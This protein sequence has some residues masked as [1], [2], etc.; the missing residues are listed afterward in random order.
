MSSEA[1]P[2]APA[3][4]AAPA[5]AVEPAAEPAPAAAPAPPQDNSA[6][7]EARA[8][9]IAERDAA[10]MRE[11]ESQFAD[12]EKRLQQDLDA[13]TAAEN[14]A[15]EKA[16]AATS[17]ATARD[18]LEAQSKTAFE[19]QKERETARDSECTTAESL[20]ARLAARKATLDEADT[21]SAL[22]E[23]LQQSKFAKLWELTVD[24]DALDKLSSSAPEDGLPV[25]ES[26]AAVRDVRSHHEAE[27]KRA[28]ELQNRTSAAKQERE[29]KN[30]ALLT[31]LR[32]AVDD[33]L[34]RL[35]AAKPRLRMALNDQ[36]YHLKRGTHIKSATV[37]RRARDEFL[38]LEQ[39]KQEQSK[40][41]ESINEEDYQLLA[42]SR[43]LDDLKREK[44]H[45]LKT[46]AVDKAALLSNIEKL[47]KEVEAV[48]WEQKTLEEENQSMRDMR[49]DMIRTAAQVRTQLRS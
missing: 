9:K 4:A 5:P 35:A 47:N 48:A 14:E 24:A 19:H 40:I 36:R 30:D 15:T 13:L 17:E 27:L 8:K 26:Q 25:E 39:A 31:E 22:E 2:T 12:E 21:I 11:Y 29:A 10:V 41:C 46:S 49:R 16:N 18:E 28:E 6:A 38:A 3:P 20:E 34:R 42:V 23:V 37:G 1:A 33:D 7:E 44:T 32:A 43:E 45:I